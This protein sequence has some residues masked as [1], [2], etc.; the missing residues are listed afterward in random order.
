MTDEDKLVLT[1]GNDNGA[2]GGLYGGAGG[3]GSNTGTSHL[4]GA[5]A[6]GIIVITYAP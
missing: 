6:Q 3:A 1:A 2:A 4:G 5:G